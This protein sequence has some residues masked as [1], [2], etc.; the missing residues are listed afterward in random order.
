MKSYVYRF[1]DSYE[2]IIYVGSC[3]SFRDR[4][5][6]HFSNGHLEQECYDMV[7]VVE[8]A[9][10]QSRTEA[11]MF[12][13]YEIGT[14]RPAF[15]TVGKLNEEIKLEYFNITTLPSWKRIEASRLRNMFEK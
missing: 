13:S 2:N 12:E 7:D 1:L 14:I 11:Y 15:N 10:F 3:G 8:Y 6:Q 4:M 5:K 9:E